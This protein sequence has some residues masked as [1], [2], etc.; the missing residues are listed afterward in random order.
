[1]RTSLARSKR[2][3]YAKSNCNGIYVGCGRNVSAGGRIG[4]W[5]A[6]SA[7]VLVLVVVLVLESVSPGAPGVPSIR[8]LGYFR[9]LRTQHARTIEDDDEDDCAGAWTAFL[10]CY[11][12]REVK[13]WV[14]LGLPKPVVASHPGLALK[15]PLFPET[16]SRKAVG[17]WYR[18][19]LTNPTRD[20]PFWSNAWLIRAKRPA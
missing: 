3:G 15:E 18:A 14:P 5:Q 8:A 7:I 13:I 12:P 6:P 1:M 4:V 19:G 9:T 16:I 2:S 17:F 20:F 11:P 10:W